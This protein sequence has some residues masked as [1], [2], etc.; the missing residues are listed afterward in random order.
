MVTVKSDSSLNVSAAVVSQLS[1]V[2]SASGRAE[3]RRRADLRSAQLSDIKGS[4]CCTPRRDEGHTSV[5]PPEDLSLKLNIQHVTVCLQL[6]MLS[7]TSEGE[8]VL[9]SFTSVEV[10]KYQHQNIV[11]KVKVKNIMQNNMYDIIGLVQYIS[12]MWC[13]TSMKSQKMEILK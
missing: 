10:Q 11:P 3:T 1:E 5:R 6:H 13:S 4:C 9:R 7:F 12:D 2:I 8:E